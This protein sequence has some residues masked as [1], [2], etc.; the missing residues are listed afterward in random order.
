[1]AICAW[2][3]RE[4]D[5]STARRRIGRRYGAGSYDDAF[6]NGD[7]CD[8]CASSEIGGAMAIGAEIMEDM[9]WDDD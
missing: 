4:F 6:P 3:G 5:V 9:G 1:M 8:E 2:C 7:V